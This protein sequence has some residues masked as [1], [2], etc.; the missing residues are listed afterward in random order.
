MIETKNAASPLT[1]SKTNEEAGKEVLIA[2]S[3]QTFAFMGKDIP[4][5]L[6]DLQ[7]EHPN[8]GQQTE[9]AEAAE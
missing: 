9:L 4:R 3:I 2:D 1:A 6:R 8:A 5:L 7:T